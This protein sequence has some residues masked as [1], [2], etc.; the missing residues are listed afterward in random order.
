MDPRVGL[1][2]RIQ[3]PSTH[4]QCVHLWK[5]FQVP[6][7]HIRLILLRLG[8]SCQLFT[9]E[10]LWLRGVKRLTQIHTESQWRVQDEN[11]GQFPTKFLLT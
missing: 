4:T 2:L 11:S 8:G 9:D 5:Y 3:S 1:G 7:Q 10:E 6:A